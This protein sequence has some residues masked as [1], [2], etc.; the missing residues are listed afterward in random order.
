MDRGEL[1]AIFV[2][3]A[4]G[5]VLRGGLVEAFGEGTA[6]WP[7]VTFAANVLGALLLGYV[8]AGPHDRPLSYRLPLLG[9]GF[10]GA[11]TTFSTMQVELLGMLD[12]RHYAMAAAYGAGS[13]LAGLLGVHLA[14]E[15]VRPARA[16]T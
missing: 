8:V 12:A 3:G 1:A 11:L 13:V 9:T 2:G 10:C 14:T 15:M 16:R 4:A 6:G 7:W 5:A